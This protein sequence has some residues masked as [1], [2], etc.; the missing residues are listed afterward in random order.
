MKVASS[1]DMQQQEGETEDSSAMVEGIQTSSL[2]YTLQSSKDDRW[3]E[4]MRGV[5]DHSLSSGVAELFAMD[6]QM[7]NGS[8]APTQR[9]FEVL[10]GKR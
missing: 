4:N 7:C 9:S 1:V 3:L 5:S 10:D 6:I 2:R 8:S